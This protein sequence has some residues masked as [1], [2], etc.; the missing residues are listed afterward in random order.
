MFTATPGMVTT[1]W[2]WETWWQ[3][4]S[5]YSRIFV[6][7]LRSSLAPSIQTSICLGGPWWNMTAPNS[8]WP[9]FRLGRL[10]LQSDSYSG[11]VIWSVL[12]STRGG[13][14]R[15]LLVCNASAPSV[16]YDSGR[17]PNTDISSGPQNYDLYCDIEVCF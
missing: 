17:S 14:I 12:S 2:M 7:C 8:G 5:Q 15:T 13:F 4:T 9:E 11:C 3:E 1:D 16:S 10:L 6:P